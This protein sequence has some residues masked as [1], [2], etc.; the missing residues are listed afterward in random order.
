MKLCVCVPPPK[1]EKVAVHPCSQP[2]GCVRGLA[3]GDLLS[4]PRARA[5]EGRGGLGEGACVQSQL[6][7]A[8]THE[9]TLG[10][11]GG[12]GKPTSFHWSSGSR[13]RRRRRKKNP[14]TNKE[15]GPELL[16]PAASEESHFGKNLS[17]T[18]TKQKDQIKW[19]FSIAVRNDV[20]QGTAGTQR[21]DTSVDIR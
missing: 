17:K 3:G 16:P 12:R 21:P 5:F 14:Q 7:E 9:D 8:K 6:E 10:K 20:A 19:W 4:R 11:L 15:R 1:E 2:Q 18:K 13:R